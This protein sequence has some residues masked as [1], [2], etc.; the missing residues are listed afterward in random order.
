MF[1]SGH[2]NWF[3]LRCGRQL[4]NFPNWVL[5]VVSLTQ[6]DRDSG[7]CHEQTTILPE[8]DMNA[9]IIDSNPS[10]WPHSPSFFFLWCAIFYLF[11]FFAILWTRAGWWVFIKYKTT[12]SFRVAWTWQIKS[13]FTLDPKKILLVTKSHFYSPPVIPFFW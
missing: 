3:K 10:T 8:S 5:R 2:S 6:V 7:S 11:F 12:L 9:P 13:W 1:L 4:L